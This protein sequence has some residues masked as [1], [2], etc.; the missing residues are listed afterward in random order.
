MN[1]GDP[2]VHV[3]RSGAVLSTLRQ[4]DREVRHYHAVRQGFRVEIWPRTAWMM[5][6]R[7]SGFYSNVN[8]NVDY[9]CWT[10]AKAGRIGEFFKRDTLMFNGCG[11]QVAQLYR[12]IGSVQFF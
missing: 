9:Q 4:D 12:G 6:P 7:G 5:L 8:P 2:T 1:S 3:W 11:E 10:Q